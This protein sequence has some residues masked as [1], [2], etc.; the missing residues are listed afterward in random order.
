MRML[1]LV[2]A[3]WGTVLLAFPAEVVRVAGGEP[4]TTSARWL[5]RALGARDLMQA[6]ALARRRTDPRMREL[7]AGIDLLHALSMAALALGSPRWRRAGVVG[8]GVATSF[9]VATW[10]SGSRR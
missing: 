8:A 9:A 5:A 10:T 4:A 1:T 7:G 6:A 2:R 3:G